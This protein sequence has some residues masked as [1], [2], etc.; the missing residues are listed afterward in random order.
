MYQMINLTQYAMAIDRYKI[1]Y[2]FS[3]WLGGWQNQ[4]DYAY[5][6]VKFY[7]SNNFTLANVTLP[8]VYAAERLNISKLIYKQS[9]G[10]IP[11]NTRY[12]KIQLDLYSDTFNNDGCA[13]NILLTLT[14]IL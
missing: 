11:I 7:N 4:D 2:N 9:T 3:A 6:W 10:M 8:I 13:D 1:S 12:A 14:H 5:L